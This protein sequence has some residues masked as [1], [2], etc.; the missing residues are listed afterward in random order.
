M[1]NGKKGAPIGNHNAQ[2][3]HNG[4]HPGVHHASLKPVYNHTGGTDGRIGSFVLGAG[5]PLL[6][7]AHGAIRGAKGAKSRA[8]AATLGGAIPGV[9]GGGIM[10]GALLGT[11]DVLPGAV[12]GGLVTGSVS[13]ASHKI[14]H[15]ITRPTKSNA[16]KR[17][18]F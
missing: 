15:M 1:K 2:G 14:G 7:G 18:S 12:A 9:I 16:H 17:R 5:S 10:T 13:G 3:H 6:A 11:D 8:G 4:G